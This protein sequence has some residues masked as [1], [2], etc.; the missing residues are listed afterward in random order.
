M[1]RE[2][3]VA[4]AAR[5]SFP[6]AAHARATRGTNRFFQ[7]ENFIVEKDVTNQNSER[8]IVTYQ[9]PTIGMLAALF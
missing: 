5:V 2:E 7:D 9:L 3:V 6:S 4:A 1:N 8:C